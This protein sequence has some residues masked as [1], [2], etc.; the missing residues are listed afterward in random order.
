MSFRL[1]KSPACST[2]SS[3]APVVAGAVAVAV[4]VAEEHPAATATTIGSAS[5]RTGPAKRRRAR[6]G[7][8]TQ[9]ATWFGPDR[10]SPRSTIAGAPELRALRDPADPRR[11]HWLR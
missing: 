2:M 7:A 8:V 9:G 11:R 3:G 1:T 10:F 5:S 6:V 4:L